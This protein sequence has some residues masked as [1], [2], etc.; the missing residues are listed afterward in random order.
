VNV[1][2]VDL[3]SQRLGDYQFNPAWGFLVDQSWVR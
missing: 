1:R 3:V 2:E